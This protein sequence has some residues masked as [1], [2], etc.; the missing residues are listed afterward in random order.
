M[1]LSQDHKPDRKDEKKRIEA[2][3]SLA[4]EAVQARLA[5]EAVEA[6]LALEAV[7][8]RLAHPAVT[9]ACDSAATCWT[10]RATC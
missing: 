5:P 1:R 10:Q 7:E 6:R 9:A 3:P 8:A 2:T 4:P